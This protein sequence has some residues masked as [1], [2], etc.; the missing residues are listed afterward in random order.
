L[1]L[2]N[3]SIRTISCGSSRLRDQSKLIAPGSA[4]DAALN[5]AISSAHCSEYSGRTCCFTT[6]KITA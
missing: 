3:A 2:T 4:R 6:I 5:S 1:A